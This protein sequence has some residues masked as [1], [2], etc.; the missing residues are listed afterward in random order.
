MVQTRSL[1]IEDANL[2][3]TTLVTGRTV[4]YKDID[5]TFTNRPSGDIYKKVDAAAVK[6]AIKNLL[7]TNN[8]EKPFK[9]FYGGNLQAML[10][11]LADDDTAIDVEGQIR[12][13]IQY[14]E[15]RAQVISVE[16]SIP[17]DVN[18]MSVTVTFRVVNSQEVI[19]FSTNITRLR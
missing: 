15:P 17:Q 16:V 4:A 7:L 12:E 11:E 18:S 5:L 3:R 19:T 10:F 9:P 13:V 1:S 6:Q 2:N 8:Y 14:Y